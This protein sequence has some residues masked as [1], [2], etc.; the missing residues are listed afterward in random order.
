MLRPNLIS[1]L[2]VLAALV[3]AGIPP[4]ARAQSDGSSLTAADSIGV[5]EAFPDLEDQQRR[6]DEQRVLRTVEMVE[7][8]RS[9]GEAQPAPDMSG[10]R[11][12]E[13]HVA[14]PVDVVL[15]TVEAE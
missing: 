8:F 12:L 13:D 2:A 11:V 1:S 10:R 14:N 6:R 3:V 15:P 4:L 5:P 9:L 7:K